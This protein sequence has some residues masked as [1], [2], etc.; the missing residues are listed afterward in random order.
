MPRKTAI[1]KERVRKPKAIKEMKPYHQ[2]YLRRL[3]ESEKFEN[4]DQMFEAHRY[5]TSWFMNK[6]DNEE[7]SLS[8]REALSYSIYV[9]LKL[10]NEPNA[11]KFNEKMVQLT[12]ERKNSEKTN[13]QSTKEKENY[14]SQSQLIAIRE[15][16]KNY[17]TKEAMYQY[18]ILCMITM[19][20]PI[21]VHPYIKMKIVHV[22]RDVKDDETNYIKISTRGS[23][24]TTKNYTG[25]FYIN[26][27]KVSGTYSHSENKKIEVNPELI[28]AVHKSLLFD[29]REH[30]FELGN[31]VK[32]EEKLLQILRSATK[33]KFD[34]DMARSSYIND[35]LPLNATELE[36]EKLA[37]MMRHNVASQ[38]L[39]YRKVIKQQVDTSHLE[40]II[41][42][43]DTMISRLQKE[44]NDLKHDQKFYKSFFTNRQKDVIYQAN[45]RKQTLSEATMADYKILWDETEAVYFTL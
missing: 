8:W 4:Y 31:V 14:L 27:D 23:T 7:K 29:P 45:K 5:Q 35:H 36:K 11:E 32:Q 10:H 18:L 16:L 17:Q 37:L 41:S 1:P 26:D 24:K 2:D 44:L 34:F 42:E 20:P 30:V 28:E 19:Q 9:Y 39:Y 43:R 3:A 33:N 12:I 25:Y 13:E 15:T 40:T 6:I 38:Q 21:R 22:D